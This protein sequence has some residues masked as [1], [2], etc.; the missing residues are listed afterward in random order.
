MSWLM[1]CRKCRSASAFTSRGVALNDG[2]C[3]QV[4]VSDETTGLSNRWPMERRPA[5]RGQRRPAGPLASGKST[6]ALLE[7]VAG[8]MP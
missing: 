2:E 1:P 6:P 8:G 3:S 5:R 4:H 7:I